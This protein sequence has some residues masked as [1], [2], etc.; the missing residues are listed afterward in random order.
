M[1]A[2]AAVAC[3]GDPSQVVSPT[4]VAA[5]RTGGGHHTE[6]RLKRVGHPQWRPVD[7]HLFSAA[8]GT[9]ES[10]FAEFGETI[11]GLL[12]PPNHVPH[13]DLGTG[14]GAPHAP[15]YDAELAH[16]VASLHLHEGDEFRESEFA[17]ANGIWL[18]WMTVP[19]HGATG[20]SPDFASGPIIPNSVMP[21]VI[22]EETTRNRELFD[23]TSY[24]AVPPLDGNLNPPFHVDGH[25]HFP[26]FFADAAVFGAPGTPT[27][28]RYA[29]AFAMTDLF[30]N[31]WTFT[32]RFEVED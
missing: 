16:G 17:G 8:I 30:G 26:Y 7:F 11:S 24:S 2:W 22:T 3:S 13:P 9:P 25:S 18:V 14:P 15:P 29:Y 27:K 12:P 23:F 6:V 10:G 31:G 19:D 4:S 28:G 32:A 20:S 21:I 1:L 5:D